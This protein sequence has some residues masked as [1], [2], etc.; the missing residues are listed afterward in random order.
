MLLLESELEHMRFWA[1]RE[2]LIILV[3]LLGS[4]VA[5]FG[6]PAGADPQSERERLVKAAIVYNFTKF[7]E[8]PQ[9]NDL[10][11][12]A[13]VLGVVGTGDDGPAFEV[14]D[15]KPV[16]PSRLVVRYCS[17]PKDLLGCHMV[18]VGSSAP[19]SISDLIGQLQDKPILTVTDT[20]DGTSLDAI[21]ELVEIENRIR[22]TIDRD[23]ADRAGLRLSSQVLKMA[24]SEG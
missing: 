18:F 11:E 1:S 23:A 6:H 7:V 8:W 17:S 15:G 20:N 14:V 12:G 3:V 9:T 22:F 16:G 13:I 19:D 21:I 24:V 10:V 2:V 4:T 5:G